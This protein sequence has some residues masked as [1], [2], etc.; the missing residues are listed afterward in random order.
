MIIYKGYLSIGYIFLVLLGILNETLFYR[1]LGINFLEYSSIL[2][3]LVSP[4]AKITENLLF[5]IILGVFIILLVLLPNALAKSKDKKWFAKLFT[6]LSDETEEEV[7]KAI[8]KILL[9][10]IVCFLVGIFVG[11][12]SGR[13]ERL[14]KTKIDAG[15]LDYGDKI[16]Y[17]D[18]TSTDAYIAGKNSTYIFYLVP[19]NTSLQIS[20]ISRVIKQ[21]EEKEASK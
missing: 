18:D 6:K 13:G 3:V 17:V 9:L 5:V 12:G 8:S 7:K 4:I 16:T 21:I 11:L 20:P 14:K 1:P 19:E 2:D 10:G 15:D